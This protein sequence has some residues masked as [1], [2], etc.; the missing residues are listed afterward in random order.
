[1]PVS[2]GTQKGIG[3]LKKAGESFM[4]G[5]FYVMIFTFE[6]YYGEKELG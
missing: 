1:M 5:E 3:T 2:A 6:V 4:R